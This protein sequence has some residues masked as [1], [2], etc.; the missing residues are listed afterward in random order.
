MR[1]ILLTVTLVAVMNSP[2]MADASRCYNLSGDAYWQCDQ[3]ERDREE[4][5][6]LQREQLRVE[7]DNNR[8]L[9]QRQDEIDSLGYERKIQAQQPQFEPDP[10]SRRY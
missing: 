6:D 5:M 7:Q 1:R 10:P 3:Q 8:L 9:Q 2:A 4:S